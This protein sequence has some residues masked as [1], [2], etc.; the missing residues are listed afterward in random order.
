MELNLSVLYKACF[1][2]LCRK[3]RKETK[4]KKMKHDEL[5][6]DIIKTQII[7]VSLINKLSEIYPE[8]KKTI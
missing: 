5:S 6:A 4:G 1:N 2:D 7:M 3:Y 8:K